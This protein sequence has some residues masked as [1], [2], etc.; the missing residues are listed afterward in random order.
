MLII[1]F[2]EFVGQGIVGT[3][4]G[5]HS[6][7]KSKNFNLWP[8]ELPA[9]VKNILSGGQQQQQQQ[10]GQKQPTSGLFFK[11]KRDNQATTAAE[12]LDVAKRDASSNLD[13][14]QEAKSL[15]ESE[16]SSRM[17]RN[18]DESNESVGD[19]EG[20]GQSDEERSN[21][22]R[23]NDNDFRESFRS[24]QRRGD[25]DGGEG[26]ARDNE[27]LL[28]DKRMERSFGEDGEVDAGAGE[29]GGAENAGDVGANY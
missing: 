7:L 3:N 19:G 28:D 23:V 9:L 2:L 15:L 18:M 14:Q 16:V 12:E 13:D 24:L 27:E 29:N 8:N 20:R 25:E 6:L 5:V 26:Q 10:Q 4:N 22:E 11:K 1:Y 17:K 21:E